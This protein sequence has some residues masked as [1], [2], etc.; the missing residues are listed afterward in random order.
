[1]NNLKIHP[2]LASTKYITKYLNKIDSN[3][4]YTNFGPLYKFTTNKIK[5]DL[6]LKTN[7]V[8]FTSSGHSSILACCNYLKTISNKRIIITTS[9]N[10]FSSPQAILQSGFEPFFVDIEKDSFSV[11]L[12]E[13]DNTLKKIKNKVAG[14][15][16]PS[17]FGYPIDVKKLNQIQ[18]KY[19]IQVIYDA[20]DA[21]L[22]FDKNLDNSKIIICC[23]F[24][25]TKTLPANES[26]LIICS[27]QTKKILESIISFGYIGK[28]REAKYLGFNGKFSEYD[29]AI[30]LANYERKNLIKK[31]LSKT[32]K[33]IST[34]IY[35][36]KLKNLDLQKDI[37]NTWI[38]HK[39]CFI[40]K[41]SNIDTLNKKFDKF[42]VSIYSA[43]NKKPIHMHRLFKN[44]SRSELINTNYIYKK[45]FTIPVNIDIN[46][47]QVEI[48]IKS[49]KKI[50]K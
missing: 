27:K 4:Y 43:W 15:I 12:K 23:S 41:N 18:R 37:G 14:I 19:K 16:V 25:P 17:P 50:F 24:H 9:F 45:F 21:F 42:G 35:K 8:I 26:G 47:K 2:K 20:A 22:N 48:I 6:K 30:F 7:D 5:N 49:I 46:L 44:F 10:F 32:L 34:R 39:L 13:L 31:K 28:N 33:N 11:N 29:A 1:M 36:L 40:S 3:R 38:S